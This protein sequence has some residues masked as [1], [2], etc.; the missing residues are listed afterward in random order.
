[1]RLVASTA[2]D[3]ARAAERERGV[4][5][6][7]LCPP[8]LRRRS[9]QLCRTF[10]AQFHPLSGDTPAAE[11]LQAG[12]CQSY[13]SGKYHV[14]FIL[15]CRRK[16]RFSFPASSLLKP[17][18]ELR[19]PNEGTG[20]SSDHESALMIVLWWHTQQHTSSDRT[21]LGRMLPSVIGSID[22]FKRLVAIRQ[23]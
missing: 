7:F 10:R 13:K 1:M 8:R 18:F 5:Q 11:D 12:L 22:S 19:G 14:V 17:S 20:T 23:L 9:G 6:L 2:A 4:Y 21:P 16:T 15:K 3:D